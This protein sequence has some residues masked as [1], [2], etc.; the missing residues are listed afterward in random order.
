VD[1]DRRHTGLRTGVL[2]PP[3]GW[4]SRNRVDLDYVQSA[5]KADVGLATLRLA[6]LRRAQPCLALERGVTWWRNAFRAWPRHAASGLTVLEVSEGTSP[7]ME[8][9]APKRGALR[10]KQSRS[11]TGTGRGLPLHVASPW[12]D[13]L[14]RTVAGAATVRSAG[15]RCA[16]S[17]R[18]LSHQACKMMNEITA[19]GRRCEGVCARGTGVEYGHPL[20]V[21]ALTAAMRERERGE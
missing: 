10:P 9:A 2:R 1:G 18:R 15:I 4:T 16:P 7:R 12:S 14:R 20:F 19:G 11:D 3:W 17:G 8:R 21:S 6:R 5:R 13:F